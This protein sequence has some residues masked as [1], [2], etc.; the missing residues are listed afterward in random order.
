MVVVSGAREVEFP[1]A[2]AETLERLMTGEE[3]SGSDLDDELDWES[4][5]VVVS[6][7]IREGW[8]VNESA[9]LDT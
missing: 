2:A 7:L 8:V 5:R 9:R 6:A 3:I 4:R 1:A